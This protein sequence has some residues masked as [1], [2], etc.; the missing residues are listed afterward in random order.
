MTAFQDSSDA[1]SLID[2]SKAAITTVGVDGVTLAEDGTRLNP[3]DSAVD[4]QRARAQKDG[5]KAELLVSNFSSTRNDFSEPI[6]HTLLSNPANR[7]R[8][9]KQLTTYVTTKHWDGISVD[10][11]S[12]RA[13]DTSGLL[14]LLRELRASL[15]K[16]ATL[17]I[18]L[19]AATTAQEYVDAG[20]D[21]TAIGRL[22]DRVMLMTYDQHGPW[23]DE[24]GPIG[25]LSWQRAAVNAVGRTI[26]RSKLDLGVA[27]Y[28]YVWKRGANDMLSVAD[29][30]KRAGS[31]ARFDVATGE[32]TARLADGSVLWWSDA[33]SY[34][35]RV[36]L[37]Q[38]LGV[39]GLA[40]WAL[41][42]SDPLT[43]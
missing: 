22:T 9:V 4:R 26:P 14:A 28:A 27:G 35:L 32:W 24:P 13:R 5:L 3:A 30:R 19:M 38:Q 6:A 33:R 2:R 25:A 23:D 15:P 12:L 20:Y 42:T 17:S 10:L 40:M 36:K 39:H 8:V 37:A 21:L 31:R 34:R 7:A 1:T 29:A 43:R 16:G 11:E 41:G 18:S